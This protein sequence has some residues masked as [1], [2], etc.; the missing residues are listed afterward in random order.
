MGNRTKK[1]RKRWASRTHEM[2]HREN[3]H[4]QTHKR[5]VVHSHVHKRHQN[6]P[7]QVARHACHL[8]F[9]CL[10][11]GSDAPMTR[12]AAY[13]WLQRLLGWKGEAHIALLTVSECFRVMRRVKE[14]YP[15]LFF[16]DSA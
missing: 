2:R 1:N 7:R 6:N 15:G 16:R 8:V 10:W 5:V 9:D 11:C 12:R 14:D 3:K 13:K 4:N